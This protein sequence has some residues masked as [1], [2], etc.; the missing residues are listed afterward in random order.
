LNHKKQEKTTM[1]I[2]H[3]TYPNVRNLIPAFGFANRSPWAGLDGEIDRLL[4]G[5]GTSRIPVELREDKDNAFVRAE[6]PG[7]N[8]ADIA[9]EI[10]D[11]VLSI[12]ATRREKIGEKEESLQLERSVS[13]PED[14]AAEKAS[15]AY[16]NGV[17][18]VTLP[19]REEVKPKKITVAVS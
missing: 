17:L 14:V 3:Y 9:V 1:R 8:R 7:V 5:T 16:E 15:S 18:T 19:K 4:S 10:V 13:L 6:L 12:T 2:V 11:G